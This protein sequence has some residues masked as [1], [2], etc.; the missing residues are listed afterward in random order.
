[1]LLYLL[2]H[3]TA[4][5]SGLAGDASRAL[6]EKGHKQV[7][8]VAGFCKA[9]KL[10]PQI[11]LTSPLRRAVETADG[12][13]REIGLDAPVQVPWLALGR[14][15]DEAMSELDAYRDHES[16]MIVGHEPDF[17]M[18]AASLLGTAAG[19]FDVTKASLILIDMV[20]P[21]SGRGTLIAFLP[22]RLM[23]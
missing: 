5:P 18:V 22:N 12:F 13:C 4:E 9:N 16:V 15:S 8:R 3:A 20:R 7:K 21:V 1:M 2:R 14:A 17:A 19:R 6:N 10:L 23:P 11:V